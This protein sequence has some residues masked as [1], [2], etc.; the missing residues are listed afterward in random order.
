MKVQIKAPPEKGKANGMLVA[1]LAKEFGLK[2]HAIKIETGKTE[3][4]KLIHIEAAPFE[5]IYS[6]LGK[7]DA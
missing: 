4:L 7:G 3:R 6:S 5:D 1:F 2:Q